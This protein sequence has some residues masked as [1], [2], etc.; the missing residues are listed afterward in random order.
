MTTELERNEEAVKGAVKI[1]AAIGDAV[2]D[3][4]SV[5]EGVLY[6]HVC[7]HMSLDAFNGA[8]KFLVKSSL[9]RKD[10]HVLVWIGG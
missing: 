9:V 5:P 10:N 3:L 1:I 2:R 7:G 4:K 8:I 6:A